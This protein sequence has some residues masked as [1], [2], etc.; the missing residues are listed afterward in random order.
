MATSYSIPRGR[1]FPNY[2]SSRAVGLVQS[3]MI[4]ALTV[5]ADG[6]SEAAAEPLQSLV[7]TWTLSW[8]LHE[9]L[10]DFCHS[11]LYWWSYVE[12]GNARRT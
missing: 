2:G 1:Y 12:L 3:P 7:P 4:A 11:R 9:R 6:I 10:Q 8:T 5:A